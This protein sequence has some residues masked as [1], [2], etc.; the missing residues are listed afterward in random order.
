MCYF[1][2]ILF[3][4]FLLLSGIANAKKIA[5]IFAGGGEKERVLSG[6]FNI[7]QDT[8]FLAASRLKA[9]GW[10]VD[11]FYGSDLDKKFN[12]SVKASGVLSR[13]NI[14]QWISKTVNRVK[15]GEISANDQILIHINTHGHAPFGSKL[16]HA[17]SL[18]EEYL[19][20]DLER[21]IPLF[22]ILEKNEIKTAI[23]DNSCYS[24]ATLDFANENVCVISK[25]TSYQVGWKGRDNDLFTYFNSK[26]MSLEDYYLR[27][28]L[29]SQTKDFPQ[30][31]TEKG[32]LTSSVLED[33]H[34]TVFSKISDYI[35]A[36]ENNHGDQSNEC[37]D[38][39]VESTE[40]LKR[41]KSDILNFLKS[42]DDEYNLLSQHEKLV[43]ALDTYL[44]QLSY[45]QI[46]YDFYKYST[47]FNF[48]VDVGEF[49]IPFKEG[50]EFFYIANTHLRAQ[51]NL[52]ACYAG[53]IPGSDCVN[54]EREYQ[55]AKT[56]FDAFDN[57]IQQSPELLINY[58]KFKNLINTDVVESKIN[59]YT[60]I[61][62]QERLYYDL[63]YKRYQ[64]STNPCSDFKL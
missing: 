36:W 3:L 2:A 14:E 61:Y 40:K 33:L 27:D 53:K 52:R 4:S 7:F 25:S 26:R 29:K 49:S 46:N 32:I 43:S 10:E 17:I 11:L 9:N 6:K 47:D 30:I 12:L 38:P 60:E 56:I 54:L 64:S 59:S 34:K 51:D 20:F 18:G 45:F 57:L 19:S 8:T 50:L 39:I 24:G 63:I 48:K 35:V 42:A 15:R 58:Y 13:A 16:G 22:T 1:R 31:S 55:N 21:L 28:R 23:V 41:F 44:E 62:K 37:I 5:V